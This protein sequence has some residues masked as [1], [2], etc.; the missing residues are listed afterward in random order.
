MATKHLPDGQ[1]GAAVA[2]FA[3]LALDPAV[4]PPWVL[5]GD[6]KDQLVKLADGNCWLA[7]RP[8]PVGRPLPADQLAMP[9]KQ[10]LG[11]GQE[12]SPCRLGQNAADPGQ[13]QTVGGLPAGPAGLSFQHA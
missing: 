10:R 8:S 6:A 9:P 5:P 11:A 3:E 2:K 12:R 4:A 7:A 13:Y 1:V